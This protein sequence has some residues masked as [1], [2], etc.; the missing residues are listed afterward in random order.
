MRRIP[1]GWLLV[2]LLCLPAWSKK[3]EGRHRCSWLQ[4]F[5]SAK[6]IRFV[7]RRQWTYGQIRVKSWI[8]QHMEA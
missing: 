4:T 7:S 8:C 1:S 2:F 3:T 6:S 5:V